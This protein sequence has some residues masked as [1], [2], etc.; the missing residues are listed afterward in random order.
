[1]NY[2]LNVG[3]I[4]FVNLIFLS[5][6]SVAQD[7]HFSQLH[8]VPMLLNPAATGVMESELRL[9]DNYRNQWKQLDFPFVTNFLS[10]DGKMKIMGQHFGIG[11]YYLHDESSNLYL[12][13]DKFYLSLSHSTYFRNNQLVIGIQPGWVLK[14]LDSRSISFGT[15]FNPDQEGFDPNLPSGE[16]LLEDDMNYFDMNFGILWRSK[17][18]RLFPTAGISINHINRPVE[19]FY[20][21]NDST[22]LPMKFSV[23]GSLSIPIGEKYRI[24][25]LLL[26][27]S[28]AGSI[29]FLGGII[30]SYYPNI[31]NLA[32]NKLFGLTEFRMDPFQTADALILG[33]GLGYAAF[34]LC[35]SY[36]ITVSLLSQASRF[37][38]AFEISIVYNLYRQ[39]KVTET[40]PCFM[41]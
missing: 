35:I 31:P 25:P 16:T 34:D 40:E 41:L 5:V 6:Y 22:H 11:G 13:A 15:Q 9:T 1:M 18:N 24:L 37:Q 33:G 20:N 29:E 32:V 10:A 4:L 3:I 28:T 38:R 2:R 26:Y 23:H 27:A 39:K 19:S 7:V 14:S 17:I 21:R 12:T 36:D 8:T 30:A